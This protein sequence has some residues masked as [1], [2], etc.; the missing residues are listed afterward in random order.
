[1]YNPSPFNLKND[2]LSLE[3]IQEYPL[4]LL[5]SPIL[6]QSLPIA[7]FYPFVEEWEEGQLF[8]TTHLAKNNKQWKDIHQNKVLVQ[9]QGPSG[10]VSPSIYKNPLNVPTWNYCTVAIEGEA[11]IISSQHEIRRILNVMTTHFE[12]M[13]NTKWKSQLPEEFNNKLEKGILGI[14][15]KVDQIE[16]KFK[17]S[18][19]RDLDDY[20]EVTRFFESKDHKLSQWLKKTKK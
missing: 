12:K 17:M 8:I 1:M 20:A 18:Q 19:N 16:G 2:E 10:Y 11:Q 4:G 5:I 13:N 14:R 6:G 7:N 15:V 9:F 3:L